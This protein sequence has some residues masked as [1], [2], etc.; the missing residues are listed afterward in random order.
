MQ[1]MLNQNLRNMNRRRLSCPVE[2]ELRKT[3]S[4]LLPHRIDHPKELHRLQQLPRAL[5]F[6]LRLH[7]NQQRE[8]SPNHRKRSLPRPPNRSRLQNKKRSKTKIRRTSTST[9]MF[10]LR[11]KATS[12]VNENRKR[13]RLI[14]EN[15][16][17]LVDSNDFNLT[18]KIQN[19]MSKDIL[20]NFNS[21]R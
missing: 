12:Q 16:N 1:T 10:L 2:V 4:H 3:L 20:L 5:Q 15:K 18:H 19:L 7:P 13:I 21:G 9:N 11:I 17:R 8:P 6:H 14:L